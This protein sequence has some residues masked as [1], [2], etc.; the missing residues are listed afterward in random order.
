MCKRERQHK[1]E[2]LVRL[3]L[4]HSAVRI[5]MTHLLSSSSCKVLFMKIYDPWIPL[6]R[7]F[8]TNFLSVFVFLSR[9]NSTYTFTQAWKCV[10]KFFTDF[11]IFT[12]YSIY[13]L[14]FNLLLILYTKNEN[15]FCTIMYVQYT[16]K[17]CRSSFCKYSWCNFS[18]HSK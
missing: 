15:L 11:S 18:L 6:V 17:H 13:Y 8:A 1:I 12:F 7:V 2:R 5:N 10:K 16:E 3:S 14:W 9:I 4:A